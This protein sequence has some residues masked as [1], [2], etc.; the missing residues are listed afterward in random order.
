MGIF[1]K[2]RKFLAQPFAPIGEYNASPGTL[3]DGEE[4][5]L[6]IDAQGNLKVSGTSTADTELPAAS[7][8]ADDQALPNTSWLKSL[9]IANDG[10]GSGTPLQMLRAGMVGIQTAFKG[11]LNVIPM[12]RYNATLP[13]PLDGNMLPIQVDANGFLRVA[14]QQVDGAVDNTNLIY[15]T[16]NK[17][18]AAST[19][20]WTAVNSTAL[21]TNH[22]IKSAA[23]VLRSASIRLDSTA[24]TGTY[25][26]QVLNA[27]SLPADGAVT[28]LVP[29]IKRI[30]TSG[31][32]DYIVLDFTIN[33]LFCSTGCVICVST[34]EFTKTIS[35]AYL[36]IQALRA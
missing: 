4:G 11:F 20:C 15:A 34:T 12:G 19:Y 36:S 23:G 21:E 16:Q 33:G 28:H 24:P 29:P 14:E 32:D 3:A 7:A 35:G 5:P 22:L 9:L 25:Y 2:V 26:I 17:P 27:T 10:T 31:T 6:Q 13:T 8:A 1:A 30:H 18:L